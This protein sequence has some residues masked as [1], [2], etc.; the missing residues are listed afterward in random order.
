MK[1]IIIA[2][3][4]LIVIFVGFITIKEHNITEFKV[5]YTYKEDPM[6]TIN[7]SGLDN[8][9]IFCNAAIV[10]S[11][12][13]V[14]GKFITF[15]T[16][17]DLNIWEFEK[18][19]LIYG[20]VPEEIIKIVR[21]SSDILLEEDTL[22]ESSFVVGEDYVLFLRKTDNIFLETPQYSLMGRV[23]IPLNDL[24][25]ST[26]SNGTITYGTNVSGEQVI[27][28][29]KNLVDEKG[30]EQNPF[31][32]EIIED[33]NIE[34]VFKE[35][36]V[37]LKVNVYGKA[38]DARLYEQSTYEVGIIEVLKG[39]EYL[40]EDRDTYLLHM[41][42]NSLEQNKEYIIAL[43]LNTEKEKHSSFTLAALN[44]IVS[45]EDVQ[46]TEKIYEWLNTK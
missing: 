44:G 5:E 12:G 3:I 38:L 26:W 18:K 41:T 35:A 15:R 14:V 6:A 37:V 45:V 39:N 17:G 27:E 46:T 10:N 25:S 8:E 4:S 7:V 13:G 1:K 32:A 40:A 42:K 30:Y 23:C 20:E 31:E 22:D 36:E 19:E 21:V 11:T 16:E 2:V 24:N 9:S 34:N 33:D 29:Y 43:S 28:Y